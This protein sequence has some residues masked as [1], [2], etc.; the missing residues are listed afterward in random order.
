MLI[1][2]LK[3]KKHF[4]FE[5]LIDFHNHI[6]PGID[7]GSSNHMNSIEMLKALKELRFER[8]ICSPHIYFDFF[9]NS[10]KTI[11]P[12]YNK[13]KA[14]LPHELQGLLDGYGAEYMLNPYFKD[15]LMQKKLLPVFKNYLLVETPIGFLPK[16]FEELI[17]QLIH[18]GYQPILAH[19]ERYHY[20]QTLEHLE[21][22]KEFG[23]FL[24]LN[25]LSLVSYY[26]RKAKE[27]AT[28]FLTNNLYDFV[29][30][31]VHSINE[32]NKLGTLRLSKKHLAYW[33]KLKD[34][35]LLHFI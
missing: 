2:F 16:Y 11:N 19:P 28:A 12:A 4:Y 17:A 10:P 7:D 1:K 13:I 25:S 35:H 9:P 8:I 15:S 23:C 14:Y 27:K 3:R 21:K 32:I 24:Q 29:C 31:D 5:S 26:G 6:I 20:I 18:N 22:I 34:K 30:S 33:D